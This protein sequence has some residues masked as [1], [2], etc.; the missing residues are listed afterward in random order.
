MIELI[1]QAGYDRSQITEKL[2]EVF[3]KNDL[4]N[5][6]L[7]DKKSVLLKPNFVVPE[8]ADDG[9]TTH[10]D[11]YMAIAHYLIQKGYKVGI[12]ESPAFGSCRKA[13]KFH[14]V[15]EEC[16]KHGISVVE[17]KSAQKY[18]GVDDVEAYKKLSIAGELQKWDAIINL[19]KIKV[20][21]QFMFTAAAK[22]LYGCV[23]GKRKFIRHNLCKNDPVRFAKMIVAN[24]RQAAC[25]LH[26][27]DG[28]EAMH[29][30]GP[31]GGERYP[32]GKIVIADDFLAHDWLVCKLIGLNP[33]KTPLFKALNDEE[34]Q[35]A[36]ISCKSVMESDHFA[37]AQNFIQ[38]YRTDISFNPWHLVRSQWRS[39]K[40][41]LKRV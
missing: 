10:P 37:V 11:F 15:Y 1:S 34:R 17:F 16:K 38:S 31:R 9:A 35:A 24:A 2:D 20:H 27:G 12:G 5:N 6:S 8:K 32:L 4:L 25:V 14:G 3:Q 26:I 36:E 22:N 33:Q 23:T 21:Q 18:E 13:L 19:P 28:V 39:L 40:F 7:A 41:K 29:V 30:K